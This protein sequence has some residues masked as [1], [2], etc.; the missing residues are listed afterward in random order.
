[1]KKTN[2]FPAFLSFLAMLLPGAFF[3][4]GTANELLAAN[5][6]TLYGGTLAS[7]TNDPAIPPSEGIYRLELDRESGTL[8]NCGL[9]AAAKGPSWVTK[10][11]T[12]EGVYYAAA[13][14]EDGTSKEGLVIAFKKAADGTLTRLNS[15][16]SGGTCAT[17]MTIHPNGKFACVANYCSGQV[18]FI[19]LNPDGSLGK[20]NSVFQLE[21]SGPNAARQRQSYAHFVAADRAGRYSLCCDL[22]GDKI[23]SFCFDEAKNVWQ[24]NPNFPVTHSASGSGPRHL[25]F[26]PNG[27]YVYVLNE[28]SC[29][30]DAFAYDSETGALTLVE[31]APTLPAGFRGSN[32]SAAIDVHPS[33]K[34]LYV[35]NRGANLI[36]VF[37]LDPEPVD[38]SKMEAGVVLNPIQY[39]PSGGDFPRFAGLDPTG[40][41]F[42]ACNK[43]SHNVIAFRVNPTTGK[44]TQTGSATIAWCTSI[45]W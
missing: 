2:I 13:N 9:A 22:G 1:M 32:K 34:S 6:V 15:C 33:G 4:S 8:V 37:A 3:V 19:E 28:L 10:H 23:W 36:T 25:A 35:T 45:A 16:N 12:L 5:V 40:D 42:L 29:T 17:H 21:G 18:S 31:S 7:P 26:A 39:V 41:F 11:P 38:G 30:L 43:K 44:L 24:P 27:K 20:L 14:N